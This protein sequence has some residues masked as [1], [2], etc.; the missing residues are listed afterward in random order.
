MAATAGSPH[1][2]DATSLE[3]SIIETRGTLICGTLGIAVPFSTQ[4]PKTRE[5]VGY[6]VDTC[7]AVARAL[8]VKLEL[9][10][11][12]VDARIP[13]LMQGLCTEFGKRCPRRRCDMT[14]VC[15]THEMAF[16][17]RCRRSSNV[18]GCRTDS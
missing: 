18:H 4:E 16:A 2:F 9:K 6:D 7:R 8:N 5:I 17:L 12:S 10:L 14:M 15:V 1:A 13:E 11:V 3:L